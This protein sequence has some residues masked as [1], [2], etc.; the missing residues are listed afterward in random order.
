MEGGELDTIVIFESRR[1]AKSADML[2]MV[3]FDLFYIY[4]IFESK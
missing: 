4:I 1:R 3:D 2:K